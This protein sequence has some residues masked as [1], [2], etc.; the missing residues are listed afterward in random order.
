MQMRELWVLL[1][2]AI[3]YYK[4]SLLSAAYIKIIG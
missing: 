1:H 3:R 4:I 2:A